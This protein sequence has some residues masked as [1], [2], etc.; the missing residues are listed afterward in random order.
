MTTPTS[1]P[2]WQR[3]D[4]VGVLDIAYRTVDSPL[5]ALLLAATPDGLL[6]I[7]FEVEGHAQVL[8]RLADS[9]SPRILAAPHRLDGAGA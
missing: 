6:R 2:R 3:A 9:V 8:Q 5:G 4:A 7:A 1:V